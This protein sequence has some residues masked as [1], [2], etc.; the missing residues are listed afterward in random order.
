M[1]RM[2]KKF[3]TGGDATAAGNGSIDK[4]ELGELMKTIGFSSM[5]DDKVRAIANALDKDGDE[6]ISENEFVAWY[7]RTVCHHAPAS[8]GGRA[9][10]A[11]T[12]GGMTIKRSLVA[13]RA[14]DRPLLLLCRQRLVT[15]RRASSPDV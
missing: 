3:D 7:A 6:E 1:R 9:R 15:R 5:T 2:F 11:P 14:A 12:V 4:T 13:T 10:K 8:A